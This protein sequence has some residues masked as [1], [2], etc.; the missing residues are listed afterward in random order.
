MIRK[1]GYK[2]IVYPKI[3][4]ILLYDMNEDP[5]EMSDLASNPEFKTKIDELFKELIAIQKQKNDP[6]D[7]N[8]FYQ[9]V[10]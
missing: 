6:L 2:L 8:E 9:K 4:K 5:E 3:D 1:D 7:L 10:Q